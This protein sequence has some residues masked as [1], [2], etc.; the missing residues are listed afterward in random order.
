[1][2]EEVS[3]VPIESVPNWVQF[4]MGVFGLRAELRRRPNTRNWS[5]RVRLPKWLQKLHPRTTTGKLKT[6]IVKTTGE[7]DRQKAERVKLVVLEQIL[8]EALEPVH[9]EIPL[10]DAVVYEGGSE[11]IN[12]WERQ[13]TPDGEVD[14]SA[15]F[16]PNTESD[17]KR[18][19]ERFI[20]VVADDHPFLSEYCE[21]LEH[22]AGDGVANAFYAAVKAKSRGELRLNE[23]PALYER[24]EQDRAHKPEAITKRTL[25]EKLKK[26][27]AFIEWAERRHQPGVLIG[28]LTGDD[29]HAFKRKLARTSGRRSGRPLADKTIAKYLTALSSIWKW[30]RYEERVKAA[31]GGDLP[32]IWEGL[33]I[34]LSKKAEIETRPF[35]VSEYQAVQQHMAEISETYADLFVLGS[36]LGFRLS[37][38]ANLT[39]NHLRFEGNTL[40]RVIAA[41]TKTDAAADWMPVICPQVREVLLRRAEGKCQDDRLF[42]PAELFA[43]DIDKPALYERQ[44]TQNISRRLNTVVRRA[45]KD[46]PDTERLNQGIRRRVVFHSTRHT[47]TTA[48]I[49][50]GVGQHVERLR[51]DKVQKVW[52]RVYADQSMQ[53]GLAESMEKVSALLDDKRWRVLGENYEEL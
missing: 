5:V 44:L 2:Q 21:A 10:A 11:R 1:M 34:G 33:Q 20:D 26:L 23:I 36:R 35:S 19:P 14:V 22:M 24:W 6:E 52:A 3:A 37:E 46:H 12:R 51:R 53:D 38:A 13:P 49:Q 45:L 47:F 9:R 39:V 18:H 42:S 29:A 17:W 43:H 32:N 48:V 31:D 15:L 4:F 41:G 16:D 27:W 28:E 50:S 30:A 8:R 40:D 25:E 7:S